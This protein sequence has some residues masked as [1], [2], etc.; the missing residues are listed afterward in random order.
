[1][2]YET[3]SWKEASNIRSIAHMDPIFNESFIKRG[4]KI[5]INFLLQHPHV[6]PDENIVPIP[7]ILEEPNYTE[8]A[9]NNLKKL[10]LKI[11]TD[12]TLIQGPLYD[13]GPDTLPYVG[14]MQ[15]QPVYDEYIPEYMEPL[16]FEHIPIY[17][18]EPR[19][20]EFN[21]PYKYE[22]VYGDDPLP[23]TFDDPYIRFEPIYDMSPEPYYGH[24][25]LFAMEEYDAGP[26]YTSFT[27]PYY[28]TEF[29]PNY[30]KEPDMFGFDDP[31]MPHYFEPMYDISPRADDFL[32]P[33][34][35]DAIY[36]QAPEP[37]IIPKYSLN[38]EP[39]YDE[40]PE[41]YYEDMWHMAHEAMYDFGP[42]Y[43]S[44]A[45]PYHYLEDQPDYDPPIVLPLGFDPYAASR[46]P[47]FDE[48]PEPLPLSLLQLYEPEYDLGPEW[49]P[50][51]YIE[52]IP[53]Y[54]TAPPLLLLPEHLPIYGETPT[55]KIKLT[56][57]QYE[58]I[59]ERYSSLL[60]RLNSQIIPL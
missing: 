59:I 30:D 23:F 16:E 35:M 20:S 12:Y 21:D 46:D 49:V 56:A 22:A 55:F 57:S 14:I 15:Y 33:F 40:D 6:Y 7:E 4:Y 11:G 8:I 36:D 48:G 31:F 44:F 54:D 28:R 34:I 43:I 26:E 29:L 37:Y 9:L 10:A 2:N 1:M 51:P 32:D 25:D 41:P 58:N 52:H 50:A 38:T 42:E 27:D 19:R 47:Y 53:V 18:L 45:D 17:D 13:E 3:T 60:K 39:V 24:L 5:K